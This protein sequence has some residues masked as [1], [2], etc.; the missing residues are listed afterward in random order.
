M[1]AQ[2]DSLSGRRWHFQHGPI[3]IVIGADGDA[4]VVEQ[5]HEAAWERFTTVL[6]ELVRELPQL[7]RPVGGDCPVHG[8]IARRMWHACRPH[9]AAFITPMAA[10][11]GSVAQ[12]LI[13]CY[14]R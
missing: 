10:V 7:R 1:A 8:T 6:D 2:R 13:A 5:A 3:D 4:S 14:D 11:A 12:E 9:A